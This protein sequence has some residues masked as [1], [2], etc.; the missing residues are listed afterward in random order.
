MEPELRSQVGCS[1][2]APWNLIRRPISEEKNARIYERLEPPRTDPNRDC[3]PH[4]IPIANAR[5]DA[6]RQCHKG[7]NATERIPPQPLPTPPPASHK[8]ATEPQPH[9][10]F[11]PQT[12]PFAFKN[13]SICWNAF[14][15]EKCALTLCPAPGARKLCEPLPALGKKAGMAAAAWSVG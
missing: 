1:S 13:A 12:I 8:P 7:S 3:M 15:A 14:G 10:P 11:P 9:P 6:N 4:R 2:C 5:P